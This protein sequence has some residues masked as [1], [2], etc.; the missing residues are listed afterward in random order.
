MRRRALANLADKA[1]Y[2]NPATV[3]LVGSHRFRAVR[4]PQRLELAP[5]NLY[6]FCGYR[7]LHGNDRCDPDQ[8]RATALFHFGDPHLSD[9]LVRLLQR[10]VERRAA[11]ESAPA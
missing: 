6:V 1:L 4:P 7:T 5:G 2:Q 9:P 11:S 3:R 10:R 8:L